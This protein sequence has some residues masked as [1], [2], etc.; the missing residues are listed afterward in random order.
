MVAGT[1]GCRGFVSSL[2][3]RASQGRQTAASKNRWCGDCS[4]G[5]AGSRDRELRHQ[6]ENHFPIRLPLPWPGGLVLNCAS[7]WRWNSLWIFI[8]V[9]LFL[10]LLFGYDCA[11]DN[12]CFWPD[13]PSLLG[14]S[15]TAATAEAAAAY[16]TLCFLLG[17]M[18]FAQTDEINRRSRFECW[19][20][21]N[22]D[23]G[24]FFKRIATIPV[25]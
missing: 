13:A 22:A 3:R 16:V 1:G 23:V 14:R 25:G 5:L 12:N 15:T 8:F 10:F 21:R 4:K 2:G 9:F 11:T 20:R 7:G 24:M 17:S 6:L 18:Q 19:I